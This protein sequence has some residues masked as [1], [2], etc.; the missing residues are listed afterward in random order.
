MTEDDHRPALVYRMH[1]AHTGRSA[2][3]MAVV[4][5][6]CV[7]VGLLDPSIRAA[8]LL[9]GTVGLAVAAYRLYLGATSRALLRIDAKGITARG[10]HIP[11]SQLRSVETMD[12]G[13]GAVLL[14][15]VPKSGRPIGIPAEELQQPADQVVHA[16]LEYQ[17]AY[18][19]RELGG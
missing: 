14:V 12:G 15:L 3:L 8:A 9:V 1:R 13:N 6:A 7:A 11:W 19:H 17:A 16:V 5:A 4:S 18:Q 10:R 2:A